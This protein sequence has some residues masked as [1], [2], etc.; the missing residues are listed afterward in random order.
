MKIISFATGN[1]W[2]FHRELNLVNFISNL[3]VDGIEY[4]YGKSIDER[5]ILD[6]DLS[7]FRDFDDV[8]M[9]SPFGLVKKSNSKLNLINNF[10]KISGDYAKICAKRIVI[11]PDE[12]IPNEI[13]KKLKI[14]FITENLAPKKNF[15]IPRLG[16]EKV[17]NKNENFG[18]CLDVSHSYFWGVE[19][20]ERIIKKWKSRIKQVHFSN[21][22]YGKSHLSF[23]KVSKSFLKSIEP[24]NELNVP[25][26]IEEDMK[27]KSIP[28]I[29]SEI[30]RIKKILSF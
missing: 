22:F 5:P 8:S 9:H 1:L 19:E 27:T 24:L 28:K 26:V 25:F 16:F 12:N 15:K 10:N 2:R 3:G 6:K 4:T 23:E 21:N 11:H 14:N 18:L 7:F 30:K 13:L 29:K 17:L 20:T